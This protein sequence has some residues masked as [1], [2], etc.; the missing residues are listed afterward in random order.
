MPVGQALSL[1]SKKGYIQRPLQGSTLLM[2][3]K[4]G[5]TVQANL[6][7]TT[8]ATGVEDMIRLVARYHR[9]Y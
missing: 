5:A 6:L 8:C 4:Q 1:L 7:R 9:T 2:V 3:Y